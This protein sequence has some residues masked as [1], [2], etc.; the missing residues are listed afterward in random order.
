MQMPKA[1]SAEKGLSV[2]TGSLCGKMR[3]LLYYW[4]EAQATAN[5]H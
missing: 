5:N 1:D 4:H 3:M 2:V